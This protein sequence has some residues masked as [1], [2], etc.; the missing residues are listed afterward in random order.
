MKSKFVGCSEGIMDLYARCNVS[1][2]PNKEEKVKRAN[3]FEILGLE[4]DKHG[5]S[6]EIKCLWF[7]SSKM[8]K[9]YLHL[10]EKK[11]FPRSF[12]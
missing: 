6:Q 12:E 2:F 10:M 11:N 7:Q 1:Y 8:I 4:T 3:R 9:N 5:I